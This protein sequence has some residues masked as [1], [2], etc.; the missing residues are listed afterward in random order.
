VIIFNIE[1]YAG[2]VSLPCGVLQLYQQSV[3]RIR[4]TWFFCL[5]FSF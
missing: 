2:V 4:L 3:T 5:L 1:I